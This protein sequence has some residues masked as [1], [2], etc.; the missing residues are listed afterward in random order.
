MT[1][2]TLLVVD[3][4]ETLIITSMPV[5][6]YLNC[7]CVLTVTLHLLILWYRKHGRSFSTRFWM[8]RQQNM[9]KARKSFEMIKMGS[10]KLD[11][12]EWMCCRRME[13]SQ[14]LLNSSGENTLMPPSS[15]GSLYQ[16]DLLWWIL[17]VICLKVLSW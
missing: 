6:Y 2:L 15:G 17:F 16:M 10:N 3:N 14:C 11:S 13:G 4:V 9:S 7:F 1:I 5:S 12:G 8:T